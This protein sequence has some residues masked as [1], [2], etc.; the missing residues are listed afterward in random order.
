MLKEKSIT[1]NDEN[2]Q[3]LWNYTHVILRLYSA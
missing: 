1:K 2:G 3:N